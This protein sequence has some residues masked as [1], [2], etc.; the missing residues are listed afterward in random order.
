[1]RCSFTGH[2]P[3][4]LY[5]YNLYSRKYYNL[6]KLLYEL[7]KR[8]IEKRNVT[9]FI[10]GGAIG[11]DSIAFEEIEKLKSAYGVEN[12]LAIPFRNQD[13]KWH[14]SNKIKYK[15]YKNKANNIHYVD[16]IE[17]YQIK[18]NVIGDYSPEKMQER[19]CY[20]VDNS[21]Y[22]VACWDGNKKGGTWNCIKYALKKNKNILHINPSTL[23]VTWLNQEDKNE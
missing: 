2:R 20:M 23:K 14:E 1:M 15:E 11:F 22:I 5:G 21:D 10:S 17:K 16:E 3:D 6:R 19:N 18:N 13:C 8:L 12:N 4:K 9:T 7:C